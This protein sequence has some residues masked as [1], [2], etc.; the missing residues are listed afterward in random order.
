MSRRSWV[1]SLV[2]SLFCTLTLCR[3]IVQIPLSVNVRMHSKTHRYSGVGQQRWS[4]V[5]DHSLSY[6]S[7]ASSMWEPEED[8]SVG[9]FILEELALVDFCWIN[10]SAALEI[11]RVREGHSRCGVARLTFEPLTFSCAR[12]PFHPPAFYFFAGDERLN[13]WTE[14]RHTFGNI[15]DLTSCSSPSASTE[16]ASFF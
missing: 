4:G 16:T 12:K 7:N 3:C 2:W 13:Q 1:Q 15:W 8:C 11:R 5:G 6:R 14:Q 9:I 10:F